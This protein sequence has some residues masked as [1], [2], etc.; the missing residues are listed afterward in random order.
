MID[1]YN[2]TSPV[3]PKVAL[4]HFMLHGQRC[5][6]YEKVFTSYIRHP[7]DIPR[8]PCPRCVVMASRMTNKQPIPHDV[9]YP[10]ASLDMRGW[11]RDSHDPAGGY[12][13]SYLVIGALLPRKSS[14]DS[15][16]QPD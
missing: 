13:P 10:Q 9:D 12:L 16:S 7:Q 15:A 1:I 4:M 6:Y 5:I 11:V 3:I 2:H 8:S 14:P